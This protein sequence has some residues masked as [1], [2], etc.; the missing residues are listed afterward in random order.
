MGFYTAFI[1]ERNLLRIVVRDGASVSKF[2]KSHGT[3][4]VDIISTFAY[5]CMVRPP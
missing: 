5:G 4:Y 3:F 2:Y 1:A